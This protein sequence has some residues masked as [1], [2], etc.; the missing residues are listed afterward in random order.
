MRRLNES[1]AG[2]VD[3]VR[4]SPF[5]AKPPLDRGARVRRILAFVPEAVRSRPARQ[6]SNTAAPDRSPVAPFTGAMTITLGFE[7]SPVR[8]DATK[9]DAG[10][11][12]SN[13][14]ATGAAHA[15]AYSVVSLVYRA[16]RRETPRS[17]SHSGVFFLG[18]AAPAPT[19]W[20]HVRALVAVSAFCVARNTRDS[21]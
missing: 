18:R 11:R 14:C 21:E 7:E 9:I 6:G 2:R 12:L 10:T 8:P 20:R 1:I 5:I 15:L 16:R 4:R 19:A 17:I 13:R 3:A